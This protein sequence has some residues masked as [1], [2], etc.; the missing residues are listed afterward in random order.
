MSSVD[1]FIVEP[2]YGYTEHSGKANK[3]TSKE[4]LKE[5]LGTINVFKPVNHTTAFTFFYH[6]AVFCC[7]FYYLFVY[8]S[9]PGAIYGIVILLLFF[10]IYMTMFSHRYCSHKAFRFRNMIYTKLFLWTSPAF[11]REEVFVVPHLV[12][13]SIT[14]KPGDPYG[15]HMGF[16]RSYFAWEL[17]Q[18]IN[19]EMSEKNYEF[20][21]KYM[22][23]IGMK[24]NSYKEFKRTGAIESNY[25]VRMFVAH[26]MWLLLSYFIGGFA[27]VFAWLS[28]AFLFI[29]IL[30]SFNWYGHNGMK[31]WLGGKSQDVDR[32]PHAVN[33]WFYGYFA[34][35]W[36]A[37]HHL[38]PGS[39]NTGFTNFQI[40]IPFYVVKFFK[41]I[42][43]I[44][45]YI[46]KQKSYNN[47]DRP[48][49]NTM[50]TPIDL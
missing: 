4:V 18:R 2:S 47:R 49:L 45:S 44:D 42:K 30:R 14:D 38:F 11:Y 50:D 21:I 35:E 24:T 5:L 37:N 40:D 15:A 20:L 32:A 13:H 6:A 43:V 3:P 1:K 8:L 33:Q 16:F 41:K 17:T 12:H 39:A 22:A 25:F 48:Q 36:H 9:V 19:T 27:F 31:S 7:F 28:A 46:D 26:S 10:Q 34:G 23:H 29:A